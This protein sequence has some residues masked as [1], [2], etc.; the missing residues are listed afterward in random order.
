MRKWFL[1][2]VAV[3]GLLTG[4][5]IFRTATA[6]SAA[7]VA[8]FSFTPAS[9]PPG[10]VVHL[11]GG[12]TYTPDVSIYVN[13]N[14]TLRIGPRNTPLAVAHPDANGDWT[15][16]ITIPNSWPN[17]DA[18]LP[19]TIYIA[20]V[21]V[22]VKPFVV[23]PAGMPRAGHDTAPGWLPLALLG[24]ALTAAGVW[25]KIRIQVASGTSVSEKGS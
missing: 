10:T 18:M 13:R 11:M 22:D 7:T 3:L 20:A 15:A 8:Y 6:A 16:T 25:L 1:L 19:G 14:D 4:S 17:G 9:G 23:T 5:G 12:Q 21:D 24:V 2:G